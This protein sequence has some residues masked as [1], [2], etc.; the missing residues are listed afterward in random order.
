L[1]ITTSI[2]IASADEAVH[3]GLL[4]TLPLTPSNS[5]LYGESI[6]GTLLLRKDFGIVYSSDEASAD[7][8]DGA[9][10]SLLRRYSDVCDALIVYAT[11]S[12]D[13]YDVEISCCVREAGNRP[14]AI[15]IDSLLIGMLAR[16]RA[17]LDIDILY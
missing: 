6:Q 17:S 15:N 8:I 7:D 2:L 11:K 1:R 9:I 12:I 14:P 13:N 10:Q 3:R 4:S 16:L 5:W